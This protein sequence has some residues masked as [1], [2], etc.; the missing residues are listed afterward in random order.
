[1]ILQHWKFFAGAGA[2]LALSFCVWLYGES[3]YAKGQSDCQTAAENEELKEANAGQANFIAALE[4]ARSE[5]RAEWD[6]LRDRLDERSEAERALSDRITEDRSAAAQSQRRYEG[7]I[8]DLLS[9][10]GSADCS[11][12]LRLR[13]AVDES[14]KR[15]ADNYQGDPG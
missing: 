4:T 14:R 12:D 9:N 6:D 8:D 5:E 1:M 7:M 11:A 13:D 10:V 3:R 2:M 15:A